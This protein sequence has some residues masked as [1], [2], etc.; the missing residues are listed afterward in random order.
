MTLLS[1]YF[2]I[3]ENS[4]FCLPL[5]LFS[6]SIFI[7]LYFGTL[8]STVSFLGEP[9]HSDGLRILDSVNALSYAE[10][11]VCE[12]PDFLN[13]RRYVLDPGVPAKSLWYQ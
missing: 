7:T 9:V 6:F 5:T 2:N 12:L 10:D 3:N 4:L 11:D 1:S 13:V 8:L